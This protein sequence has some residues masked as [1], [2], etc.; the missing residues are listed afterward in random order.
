MMEGGAEEGE[1]AGQARSGEDIMKAW[2]YMCVEC[3]RCIKLPRGVE[4]VR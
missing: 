1:L 2:S 3:T 4:E